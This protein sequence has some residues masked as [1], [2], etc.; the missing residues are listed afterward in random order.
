MRP[1]LSLLP[2]AWL[3]APACIGADSTSAYAGA[4]ACQPCHPAEYAAQSASGHARALAP[5]KSTTSPPQPGEWAFGAGSQAITFVRHRDAETYLELGQSW[6]RTINGFAATPGHP[7][8]EDTPYRTFDP[9]AGILRC[10]A[11]HSTGPLTLQEGQNIV[12]HE[13]GVR[14]EACHS[15]AGDH[16]RNP[17]RYA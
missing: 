15:P 14:C 5:S 11:C 3:L 10:F 8:G 7:N 1:L 16:A 6:F 17:A 9:S 13:L 4:Q 2:L 12:P